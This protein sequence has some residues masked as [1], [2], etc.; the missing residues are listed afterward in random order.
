MTE[1]VF[2]IP[3]LVT[4]ARLGLLPVFVWLIASDR[5]AEAGWLFGVIAATDWIDGYLAR[6]LD[7]VTELGK[8][9]DPVADR[10]AVA[11]AVIGGLLTGVLPVWFGWALIIRE[12]LIGLGALFV[13]LAAG[14]KITVRQLGK[15]ATFGVYAA[16]GWFY[17]GEG[18][19]FEPLVWM[20]YIVGVPALVMYYVVGAQYLADARAV[21]ASDRESA[22]S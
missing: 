18:T 19:P 11:I 6:K 5:I 17:V 20:A 16:V 1:R 7:Q 22:E 12:A 8:L 10:L 13:G 4:F 15:W 9:L 14:Q 2:T 3:N 21:V